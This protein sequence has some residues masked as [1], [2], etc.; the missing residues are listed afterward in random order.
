MVPAALLLIA[1]IFCGRYASLPAGLWLMLTAAALVVA[2][3][4]CLQDHLK[5]PARISLA[6]GILFAGAATATVAFEHIPVNHIVAFTGNG[7]WRLATLTGRVTTSPTMEATAAGNELSAYRPPARTRFLL[8]AETVSTAEGP[9]DCSGL[10]AVAVDGVLWDLAP[11]DRVAVAGR[12][13]RIGPSANPGGPDWPAAARRDGVMTRLTVGAAELVAVRKT[14]PMWP[15]RMLWR[16]RAWAAGRLQAGD[17]GASPLLLRAMI[18]G[19]RSGSLG[20]IQQSMV[21]AGVAHL[22]SISGFHLGILLGFAYL[23]MRT[24]RASPRAAA[25]AVLVL[26]AAYL[27][28]VEPRTPVL[29]GA[30]M[31]AAFC[32]AVI[33]GRSATTGNL[34][35]AAAMILL[36]ADP[37]EL[38]RP[39]F[40]LS[41]G[42]VAGIIVLLRPVRNLLFGRWLNIRG[43]LVFT[44]TQTLRRWW[45]RTGLDWVANLVSVS[46]AAYLA[47]APLVAYHFGIFTPLAP[48]AS[49][50]LLPLTA[51]L[52]VL[53]YFQ[54]LLGWWTPNLAD[55]LAGLL[56]P[57]ADA[58]IWLAT[59]LGRLPIS[60]QLQPVPAWAAVLMTCVIV[61]AA[62][63]R[64]LRLSRAW[65]T[66][67]V[68]AACGVF[69]V[70]TQSPLPPTG[71]GEL[72]L[73][74]VRNGQCGVFRAPSGATFVFDAGSRSLP[75]AGR[76]VLQPFMAH[77]RWP[78]PIAAFISHGE[79]DHYNALPAVLDPSSPATV[80]VNDA[81]GGDADAREPVTRL[82]NTLDAAAVDVRR[83]HRGRRVI[84]DDRT[85]ITVLWP[86]APGAGYDTLSL[87]DSSLVLRLQCDDITILLPGDIQHLAQQLLLELPPAELAADVLVLP[88]HGSYTP[89]LAAFIDAVDP[90]IVLRSSGYR[91]SGATR[92]I[93]ALTVHREFYSTSTSGALTI[94][95]GDNGPTVGEFRFRAVHD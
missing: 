26:L 42:I 11:G 94:A 59:W 16:L 70:A 50:L 63:H 48:I 36:A 55:S 49:L 68:A 9:T 52:L 66:V 12:L 56:E 4:A 1:G 22:L 71:Y 65:T 92:Q 43:L 37:A 69:I 82:L 90:K 81:F 76:S 8:A 21:R 32:M 18:L 67:A 54:L 19:R 35:A 74:D 7:G 47:A 73:L 38:F 41:F 86:P 95:I 27:L 13:T 14:R 57:I 58:L 33:L 85:S 83:L 87:N 91:A 29:R 89:A 46:V 60:F 78:R 62:Y 53:G 5:A 75:D 84:L 72:A 15:R 17:A 51:L 3:F 79:V 39:G 45:W 34:L 2:V 30:I 40:Q 20:A 24:G 64:R 28:V 10:V 77:R 25:I 93:E 44:E 88:H 6:A 23:V 31:A 61:A 80:F